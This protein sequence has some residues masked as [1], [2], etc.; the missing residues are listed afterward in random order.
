M[1]C[2]LG[3][4]EERTHKGFVSV[5]RRCDPCERAGQQSPAVYGLA[6]S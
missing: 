1:S 2:H 6:A 5:Y 3:T 4:K